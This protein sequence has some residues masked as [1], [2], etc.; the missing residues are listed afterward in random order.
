MLIKLMLSAPD[1][2]TTIKR[3]T[4]AFRGMAVLGLIGLVCYGTLVRNSTLPDFIQ[5]LYAGVSSG[6]ILAS[7][8][9]L[10]KLHWLKKNPKAWKAAAIKNNDERE[11][12]VLAKALQT[13]ATLLFFLVAAAMLIVAPFSLTAFWTLW[14]VVIVYAIAFFVS[15]QVYSKLL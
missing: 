11:Q 3:R 14:A 7:V 1:F 5:G 9:C 2:E 12:A 15:A 4:L 6:L 10:A 13:T 8:I